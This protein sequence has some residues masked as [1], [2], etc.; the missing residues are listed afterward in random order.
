LVDAILADGSVRAECNRITE[1]F[2]EAGGFVR[3]A[4]VILDYVSA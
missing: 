4:D 2:K 3:A 1:S